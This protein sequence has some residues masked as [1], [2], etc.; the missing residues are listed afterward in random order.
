MRI[1]LYR[2][3]LKIIKIYLWVKITSF[4]FK[5]KIKKLFVDKKRIYYSI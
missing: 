1:K 2:I 4:A 5:G 3:L